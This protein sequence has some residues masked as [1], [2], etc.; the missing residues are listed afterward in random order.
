M[1]IIG[2]NG[3]KLDFL[4]YPQAETASMRLDCLDPETFKYTITA[5]ELSA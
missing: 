2:S 4:L 1:T 3:P 5:K